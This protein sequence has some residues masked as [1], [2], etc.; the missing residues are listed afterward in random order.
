M[1]YICC[2]N[3]TQF[4]FSKVKKKHGNDWLEPKLYTKQ[5]SYILYTYANVYL[6]RVS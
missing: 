3:N 5:T 4:I 1:Q 6:S 2:K